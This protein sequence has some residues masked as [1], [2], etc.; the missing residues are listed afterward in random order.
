MGDISQKQASSIRT[1]LLVP[2]TAILYAIE[3]NQSQRALAESIR[4][5]FF[6]R[7]KPLESIAAG[8]RYSDFALAVSMAESYG[9]QKS[10][11]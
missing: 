5:G 4:G 2:S 6:L 9:I 7:K 8:Y 10:I 3:Q 11:A 1:D